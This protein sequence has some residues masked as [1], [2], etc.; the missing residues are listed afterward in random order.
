MNSIAVD[1]FNFNSYLTSD[2]IRNHIL[3]QPPMRLFRNI[4]YI[5][6]VIVKLLFS[7]LDR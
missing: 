7:P 3:D 2:L 5:V 6:D 4:S 1:F